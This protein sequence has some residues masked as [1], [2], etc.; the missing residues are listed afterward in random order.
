MLVQMKKEARE[1]IQECHSILESLEGKVSSTTTFDLF[2]NANLSPIITFP[3][4]M[5]ELED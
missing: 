2:E 4:T 1:C 5:K 3:S